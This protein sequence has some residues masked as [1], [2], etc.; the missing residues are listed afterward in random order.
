MDS[1]F[2]LSDAHCHVNGGGSCS[3]RGSGRGSGRVDSSPFFTWQLVVG[4]RPS[5]WGKVAAF[6]M[7]VDVD[8]NVDDDGAASPAFLAFGVHPWYVEEHFDESSMVELNAMLERHPDAGVGEIGLDRVSARRSGASNARELQRRAFDAQ[9]SLACRLQRR[10]SV[11]CVREHGTLHEKLKLADLN[12]MMPRAINLHSWSGSPDAARALLKLPRLGCRLFF[13]ASAAVNAPFMKHFDAEALFNIPAS[14]VEKRLREHLQ[15]QQ[16]EGEERAQ[17][18][19]D[20]FASRIAAV[21]ANRLLLETD[22]C[23][24]ETPALVRKKSAMRIAAAVAAARANRE[25]WSAFQWTRQAKENIESF[26]T[27]DPAADAIV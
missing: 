19:F 6:G 8:G 4:T 23:V 2:I 17:K 11:H 9:L 7:D 10:V 20:K 1:T 12:P 18:C 3:G 24:V 13:G 16:K 15:R 25:G 27:F 5:D 22:L 21:P 26:L 14:D